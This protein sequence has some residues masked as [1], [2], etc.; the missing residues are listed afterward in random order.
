MRQILRAEVEKRAKVYDARVTEVERK[1]HAL[2]QQSLR[3]VMTRLATAAL[4]FGWNGLMTI[5]ATVATTLA[6][7]VWF[8][9]GTSTSPRP[10]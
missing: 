2:Q 3:E 7:V 6:V 4:G 10:T 8:L 1:I 9:P 5:V